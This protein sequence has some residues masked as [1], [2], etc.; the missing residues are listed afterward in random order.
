MKMA[1]VGEAWG[2]DEEREQRPFVG[3][4]GRILNGL[5]AQAGIDRDDCLVTNVFNLRPK[6]S[7]NVTNLCG[8]KS[9]GIPDMPYLRRG[10]YVNAKY[11]GELARLHT[12]INGADPNI[13]V[14]FG[15]TAAWA[16][17]GSSG[18]RSIRGAPTL[19]VYGGGGRK[20]LPTYHPAAVM[21]D[22]K[23][24]PIV[25]MDLE[26]AKREAEYPE[27]VRP[28]RDIWLEPSLQTIQLF[29]AEHMQYGKYISIDI[30]TMGDIITCVGF[31][32]S[33]T[34]ALVIPFYDPSK[35]DKNYWSTFEEERQAWDWVRDF[36]ACDIPKV[37]QNGLYDMHFLWRAMGIPVKNA[38][39]DTM[40]LHHAIQPEME[41]GLGFLGSIY[42]DEASWK[43]M[44]SKGT[45]KRED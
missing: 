30:E 44:R 6:P 24:R 13:V 23:L 42:T 12:E 38:L 5:L 34:H 10:K 26:K 39:H 18:I 25:Y 11:A 3:A 27:L 45:I 20:V 33:R 22:W 21:R 9:E 16:L 35:P 19:S 29:W 17:M 15:A 43:F 36:C 8:P 32:P 4:S 14:A 37:F 7:D 41:K 31:A 1:L 40:L 2:K 28:K